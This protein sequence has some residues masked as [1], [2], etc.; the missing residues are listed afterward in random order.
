LD[1]AGVVD[2]QTLQPLDRLGG[3]VMLAL[4][5]QFG[6]TRLIDNLVVQIP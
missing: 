3:Q 1:Y 4:A 2:A 5:V 6:A